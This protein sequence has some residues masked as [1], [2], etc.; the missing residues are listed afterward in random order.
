MKKKLIYFNIIAYILLIFAFLFIAYVTYI[1]PIC[2]DDFR[3]TFSCVNYERITSFDEAL[4]SQMYHYFHGIGRF[5]VHL[6]AQWFLSFDRIWFVIANTICYILSTLLISNLAGR[7]YNVY[8]WLIVALTLWI[9]IPHTGCT[10]FSVVGSFNY[11]WSLLFNAVFLVLLFSEKKSYNISAIFVA[12]VAGHAHES[13]ALGILVSITAYY[14]LSR[15]KNILFIIAIVIYVVGFAF[16]ALAPSTLARIENTTGSEQ[17][18]LIQSLLRYASNLLKVVSAIIKSNDI[19]VII[20]LLLSLI[21]LFSALFIKIRKI[22]SKWLFLTGC[23]L[24][25]S[26]FSIIL[27]IYTGVGYS[28]SFFCFC[29][30]SYVAFLS[31]CF[32]YEGRN[33]KL[34]LGI[35]SLCSLFLFVKE[36]HEAVAVVDVFKKRYS[37]IE[38]EAKKGLSII[39]EYEFWED[40]YRTSKYVE[41]FGLS[42]NILGNVEEARLWE[43]DDFS[44]F[45]KG[46]YG[47]ILENESVLNGMKEG[48]V[49]TVGNITIV[50]TGGRPLTARRIFWADNSKKSKL[51]YIPRQLSEIF[52]KNTPKRL[53]KETIIV[54]RL[55]DK[56]YTYCQKSTSESKLVIEYFGKKL[57]VELPSF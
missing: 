49:K 13:L 45:D 23:F 53:V 57:E 43:V 30:I 24:L 20:S 55:N 4:Q 19:G 42:S 21:T 3:F 7:R 50:C 18:T 12:L 56:F 2:G 46:G 52:V 32:N 14:F 41:V 47:L 51:K 11:L 31:M 28:R 44:V 5:V 54:F 37:Y 8:N 27:N 17:L 33:H 16:N 25:G 34:I 26:F 35:L 10:V 6:L 40:K 22:K 39:P 9:I 38:Q 36:A 29:V 15:K 48:E 1:Y